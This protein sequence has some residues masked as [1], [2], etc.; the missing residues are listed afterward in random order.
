[1]GSL[2]KKK[3][4]ECFVVSG[5]VYTILIFGIKKKKYIVQAIAYEKH[6]IH[7]VN[8]KEKKGHS[9]ENCPPLTPQKQMQPKNYTTL[10]TMF[11]VARVVN[12]IVLKLVNNSAIF[13]RA[14]NERKHALRPGVRYKFSPPKSTR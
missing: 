9:P 1:M 13:F 10:V 12:Q 6:H 2:V 7:N 3:K 5:I 11:T 14:A 8:L 4:I